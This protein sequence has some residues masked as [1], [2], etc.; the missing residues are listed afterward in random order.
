MMITHYFFLLL[1]LFKVAKWVADAMFV[2]GIYDLL[3]DLK[4]YPYLEARREYIHTMTIMNITEYLSTI[5]VDEPITISKLKHKLS[6]IE[7]MGYAEDGGFPILSDGDVL[8]GYIATSELT[9]G[10][11]QLEQTLESTMSANELSQVPCYFKR[12][13]NPADN[14]GFGSGPFVNEPMNQDLKT[15]V[16]DLLESAVTELQENVETTIPR[17]SLNDF[18]QYIDHVSTCHCS[19]VNCYI[20]RVL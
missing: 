2:E 11:E 16:R 5:D 4:Q 13:N 10:L 14:Y 8:E 6:I 12:L 20:D 9:H 15:P 17:Q 1:L 7:S 3:I 18:S 19:Y